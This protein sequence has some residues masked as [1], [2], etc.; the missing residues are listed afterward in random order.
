MEINIAN[1]LPVGY[2]NK[3]S[4]TEEVYCGNALVKNHGG[5]AYLYVTNTIDEDI[6]LVEPRVE[7]EAFEENVELFEEIAAQPDEHGKAEREAVSCRA[8][9]ADSEG[10]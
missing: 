7:R 6:T 8:T 3:M 4:F 10:S 1:E 9:H 5:Y 2:V